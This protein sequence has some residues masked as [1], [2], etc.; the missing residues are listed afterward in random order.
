MLFDKPLLSNKSED[1]TVDESQSTIELN[2]QIYDLCRRGWCANKWPTRNAALCVANSI[3]RVKWTK[4]DQDNLLSY[5][6]S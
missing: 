4:I 5:N 2:L 3:P 1:G 6:E